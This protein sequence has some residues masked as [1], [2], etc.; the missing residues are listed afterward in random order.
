MKRKIIIQLLF[1][2]SLYPAQ[3]HRFIYELTITKSD[4]HITKTNM[5]LDIDKKN[6]KFYDLKFIEIDSLRRA[7][8]QDL[9]TFSEV[10]QLI[11]RKTNS[12]Q[13]KQFHSLMY[14]YYAIKSVD[15]LHWKLSEETKTIEN[16]TLQKASTTFG[17]RTWTAWFNPLIPFQEGPYKFNGLPGLIFEIYDSDNI[18]H[19]VLKRN[20][21]LP[22][23]FSTHDFL[24]THYG[25]KPIIVSLRQYHKV[26][27]DYY[28]NIVEVLN[29]FVEKGGSVASDLDVTSREKIE[30]KRKSLQQHIKSSYLPIE[31][32]KAIPYP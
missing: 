10:D 21:N 6:T 19:Y 30:R 15:K 20:I 17:G 22:K 9:Q 25:K 3:I 4:G 29:R 31:R 16:I 23:T 13:N 5:V 8:H 11:L 1:L 12:S 18:F 14:N 2:Y 27:L 28:N 32:D 7:T 24:E 26:R